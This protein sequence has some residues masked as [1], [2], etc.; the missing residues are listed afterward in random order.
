MLEIENGMR[1]QEL[2]I[3]QMDK[4]RFMIRLK[5]KG[6]FSKTYKFLENCRTL[7]MNYSQL[8]RYG[9]MGVDALRDAT[10]VDSGKTADS[11][12][13]KIRVTPKS[14]KITWVNRNVNDGCNIALLLQYGHATK[15]GYY[16]T[17][18]DY[19]NPA[20][21]PIFDSIGED[22]WKEVTK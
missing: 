5:A 19:I 13:Y 14:V 10:P 17:G 22:I 4:V 1:L 15:D 2:S 21:Q 16:I 12:E 7:L 8:E 3:I 6:S 20:I 18:R 11:W 9:K